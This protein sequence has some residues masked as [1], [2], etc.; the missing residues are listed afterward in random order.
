MAG[1]KQEPSRQRQRSS[2]QPGHSTKNHFLTFPQNP[3]VRVIVDWN[4]V[5]ALEAEGGGEETVGVF[6]RLP[7]YAISYIYLLS[8]ILSAGKKVFPFTQASVKRMS[9]ISLDNPF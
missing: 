4:Q 9:S 2:V 8:P 6:F 7:K 5:H 3:L 1:R